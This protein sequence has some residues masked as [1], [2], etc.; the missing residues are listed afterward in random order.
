[1]NRNIPA[2]TQ[3]TTPP[4]STPIL[5]QIRRQ[6]GAVINMFKTAAVSPAALEALA[7]FFAAME[8]AAIP[9]RVREGIAIAVAEENGCEYCLSAHTAIGKTLEVPAADLE[10]F[11]TGRSADPKEQALIDLALALVR[12][13][14]RDTRRELDAARRAG[15][16]DAELVEV[17]AAVAQNVFTN[18]LNVTAG[19]EVDFPRVA[20]AGSHVG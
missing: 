14:A 5:D 1:M 16:S 15:A 7:G 18:Y 20:I 19:T 4:A 17:V 11:R 8:K 9:G 3:Q 10:A 2:V 13:R 6:N 12:S